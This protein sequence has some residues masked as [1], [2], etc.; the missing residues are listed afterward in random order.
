MWFWNK[1][2]DN[3]HRKF[4]QYKYIFKK[5]LAFLKWAVISGK[6]FSE[7]FKLQNW[8]FLARNKISYSFE[9]SI[10]YKR[11]KD[12][13]GSSLLCWRKSESLYYH[14]TTEEL[15]NLPSTARFRINIC[16]NISMGAQLELLLL[17]SEYMGYILLVSE[18]LIQ[19]VSVHLEE[20]SVDF[21]TCH[22]LSHNFS[23]SMMS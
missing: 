18:K 3:F 21:K 5:Y 8:A 17:I 22:T 6:M 13:K 4:W 14:R 15:P 16:Q 20:G 23:K 11:M 10:S 2:F 7:M 12:Q 9:C 19:M 1:I